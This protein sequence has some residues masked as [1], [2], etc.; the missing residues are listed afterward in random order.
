MYKLIDPFDG[1]TLGFSQLKIDDEAV[2]KTWIDE[3]G[4]RQFE[5]RFAACEETD[6]SHGQAPNPNPDS[7]KNHP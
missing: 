4:V 2:V 7:S 5:K 6:D 3:S 1:K